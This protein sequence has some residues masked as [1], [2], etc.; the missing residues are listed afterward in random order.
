MTVSF[1][2][3]IT[4]AGGNLNV[5]LDTGAVVAIPPFGLA[6]SVGATY[7]VGAGQNS[8]DLTAASPLSLAAGATLRDTAGN[9]AV[10]AIPAGLNMADL[11]AIVIDTIAPTISNVTSTT[12]NGTY[13]YGAAV[14]VTVNFSEAVT[15]AGGS[16]RVTLDTGA[17]LTFGAF[18]PA[19]LASGTYTAG[20]GQSSSDLTAASP[21]VLTGG[22]TLRDA[23]GNATTLTIPAGQNIAN[24]KAIVIDSAAAMTL[25]K[26]ASVSTGRPGDPITYTLTYLN[27][28]IL[29]L[30]NIV[31]RDTLSTYTSFVSATPALDA[32]FPDSAGA[33]QWTILGSL[34]AGAS[35]SVS[36]T[37]QIK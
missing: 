6:A 1:S 30:S 10:L 31:V 34:A 12:P 16:L 25:V 3:A 37:V 20:A 11:K 29:P 17:V 7:T 22:A 35:G 18:G 8:P 13:G 27:Y 32:G 15:L 4:L 36:C 5:T 28:G 14:N 26:S 24:L 2:E 23:A 19:L 21:L 9:N 33:L